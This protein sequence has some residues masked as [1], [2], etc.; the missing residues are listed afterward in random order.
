MPDNERRPE[1]STDEFEVTVT[2]RNNLLK[3]RRLAAGLTMREVAEGASI[4]PY[5]YGQYEA[6]KR[7]PLTKKGEWK[8]TAT[9][10]AE[11]WKVTPEVLWPGAVLAIEEVEASRTY[12]EEEFGQLMSSWHQQQLLPPDELLMAKANAERI[13]E[14]LA[15]L[16]PQEQLV[17]QRRSEGQT[18]AETAKGIQTDARKPGQRKR[19]LRN[20][21]S[22]R[23]RQIEA[24][25][26]RKLRHPSRSKLIKDGGLRPYLAVTV[27]DRLQRGWGSGIRCDVCGNSCNVST[28]LIPRQICLSTDPWVGQTV[29]ACPRCGQLFDPKNCQHYTPPR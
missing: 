11:Y 20:I 16:P 3:S 8:E 25:A 15:S 29:L 6:M 24:M 9:Q 18:L 19:K 12:G 7:S 21:S 1:I 2:I 14:V 17:I 10:L 23:V 27:R 13:E 26:M 22:M 28:E 5:V 4:K